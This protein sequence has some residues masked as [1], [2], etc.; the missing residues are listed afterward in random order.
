MDDLMRQEIISKYPYDSSIMLYQ[1][2][3]CP[4]CLEQYELS[5]ILAQFFCGHLFHFKCLQDWL[6]NKHGINKCPVCNQR[7]S[8]SH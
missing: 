7:Y 6:K 5:D 4:F 2:Q 8:E 3:A 1:Q